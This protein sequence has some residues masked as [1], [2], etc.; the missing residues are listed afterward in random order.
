M[1]KLVGKGCMSCAGVFKSERL[2]LTMIYATLEPIM[3]LLHSVTSAQMTNNNNI[4]GLNGIAWVKA[5]SAGMYAAAK[6]AFHEPYRIQY[7]L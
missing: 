6:I 3:T 1:D 2:N 5:N 7:M 4:N